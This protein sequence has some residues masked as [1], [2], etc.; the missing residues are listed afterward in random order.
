MLD[1]VIAFAAASNALA[2]SNGVALGLFNTSKTLEA[3]VAV[4]KSWLSVS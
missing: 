1:V 3:A 2:M 4:L